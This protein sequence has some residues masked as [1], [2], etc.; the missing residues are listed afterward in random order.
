MFLV[1]VFSPSVAVQLL[2]ALGRRIGSY[3]QFAVHR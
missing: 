1:L 3:V 2:E